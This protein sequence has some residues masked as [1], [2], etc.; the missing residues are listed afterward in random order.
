MTKISII[1]IILF[2]CLDK[3]YEP[4]KE[5]IKEERNNLPKS[6]DGDTIYYR[7]GYCFSYSEKYEQPKWVFYTLKSEDVFCNNHVSRKASRADWWERCRV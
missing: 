6:N 5:V 2:S 3:E 7:N 1:L 4:L